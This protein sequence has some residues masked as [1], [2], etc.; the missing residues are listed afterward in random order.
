VD[1]FGETQDGRPSKLLGM[2]PFTILRISA[3]TFDE[4]PGKGNYK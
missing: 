3:I 2:T 1:R 4:R